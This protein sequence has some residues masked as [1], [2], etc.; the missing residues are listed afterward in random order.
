M[1]IKHRQAVIK[2]LAKVY[3]RYPQIS[4]HLECIW[5]TKWCHEYFHSLLTKEKI[6]I[7]FPIDVYYTLLTL[8]MIHVIEYTDF[9]APV[10][11]GTDANVMVE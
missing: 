6:R 10:P 1:E 2:N 4:V 5:G 8:Y 11:I 7:G 3:T 9:N